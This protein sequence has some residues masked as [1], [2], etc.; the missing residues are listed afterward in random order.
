[1]DHTRKQNTD[2]D[3]VVCCV[4]RGIEAR[5]NAVEQR[6]KLPLSHQLGEESTQLTQNFIES[7]N[8][9]TSPDKWNEWNEEL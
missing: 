3:N 4:A 8:T 7:Q 2:V 6:S 5:V 1:M 9:N